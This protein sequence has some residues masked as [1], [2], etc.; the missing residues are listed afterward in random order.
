MTIVS[1]FTY[2]ESIGAAAPTWQLDIT[3][4]GNRG[5]G[6]VV[7]DL[8]YTGS[9]PGGVQAVAIGP[10][11]T[12]SE[13]IIDHNLVGAVGFATTTPTPGQIIAGSLTVGVGAPAGPLAGPLAVRTA[14]QGQYADAYFVDGDPVAKNFGGL[15]ALFEVPKLS[16]IF[17]SP[18]ARNIVIPTVRAPLIRRFKAANMGA[19]AKTLVGIWPV[20]GRK[21][22]RVSVAARGG[23]AAADVFVGLISY[24]VDTEAGVPAFSATEVLSNAIAVSGVT[25]AM[26]AFVSTAPCQYLAVYY[27][28]T[29]VGDLDGEVFAT[30]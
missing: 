20:S 27:T 7:G 2:A 16:L 12:V 29:G 6:G 30:D 26:G 5:A 22:I 14:M 3:K 4:W 10:D 17:Y 11:S 28:R 8:A 23:A 18:T 13:V 25:G 9:I 21:N 19:T 1:P 24:V 15:A